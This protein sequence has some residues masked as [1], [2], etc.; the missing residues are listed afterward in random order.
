MLHGRSNILH[1]KKHAH[2]TPQAFNHILEVVTNIETR[3]RFGDVIAWPK[4]KVC[5]LLSLVFLLYR[6]IFSAFK[7]RQPPTL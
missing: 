7:I 6:F 3:K 1:T 4:Q 2:H 5:S